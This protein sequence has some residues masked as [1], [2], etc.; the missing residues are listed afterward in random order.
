MLPILF[1]FDLIFKSRKALAAKKFSLNN[2]CQAGCSGRG[3]SDG[4]Q[5]E[6][7]CSALDFPETFGPSG[8]SINA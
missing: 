2:P 3:L 8:A 6:S 4:P 7:L 1:Y 5:R